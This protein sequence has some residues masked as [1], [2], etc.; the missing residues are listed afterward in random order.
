MRFDLLIRGAEIHDGLGGVSRG[1]VGVLGTWIAAVEPKIEASAAR[2]IEANG[3]ILAP[4][5][6]DIHSHADFAVLREPRHECKVLQGVTTEVFTSCGLGF[7]PSTPVSRELQLRQ[8]GPLFG[9][10]PAVDLSTVK[11]YL[12]AIK[13]SVNAAFLV[14]HGALRSSILGYE[15]RAATRDELK[16]MRVLARQAAE[17]GAL[18]MSAGP[19]YKPACWATVEETAALAA[20]VGGFFSIHIRDHGRR[21][22]ESFDEA[23]EICAR[24]RT[25]MQ[26]S[27]LQAIR[28]NRGRAPEMIAKMEA[29]RDRGLDVT[30]DLYPYDAG[31]TMLSAVQPDEWDDIPWDRAHLCVD[32]SCIGT[33]ERAKTLSGPYLVHDR[34]EE[35]VELFAKW[36]HSTFGSDGLHI[37]GKP[38]PR[39]WGTFPRV[40]HKWGMEMLPKMTSKAAARLGLKDR[41]VIR[42]RAAA[43]LVLLNNPRDVATFED[44]VR[45]P[46]GVDLVV[47]NGTVVAE[48]GR[49]TGAVPGQ[50]LTN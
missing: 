11:G 30:A 7:T 2:T 19:Y 38:H 22:F 47:V 41:G 12:G 24:A 15:P 25:P 5:F 35:E 10:I 34:L 45:P 31:S 29:A 18:G 46:E 50:V 26:V 40:L 42:E 17:E 20:E 1:D 4:G 9:D 14:S 37:P 21:I 36:E 6:I 33:K 39:L 28:M 27:H 23:I 32:G 49:H 43:D 16:A 44:P 3:R 48:N 8:H 13:A